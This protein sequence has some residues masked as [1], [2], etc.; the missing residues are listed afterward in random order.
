MCRLSVGTSLDDPTGSVAVYRTLTLFDRVIKRP[1]IV[2]PAVVVVVALA[3]GLSQLGASSSSGGGG[4]APSRSAAQRQLAGSPPALDALHRDADKLL[5]AKDYRA[6]I[7]A[8]KGF[9]IV[10]NIWGSWCVPCRQEFPVFQRV[11]AA[12]GREVAF[13]GVDT[14]DPED[15]ALKFLAANPLSY[16]SFQDLDGSLAKS[17]GII[18]TPSTIYY[19]KHGEQAYLHQGPY[20]EDA[21]LR[22]DIE[23]YARG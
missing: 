16:P 6:R 4:P 2:I 12:L 20:R 3:I 9:P 11:S 19:D 21:D 10:V 7:A 8:L 22:A 15:E 14:Q 1:Q 5:P 23:R 17:F 13:V 18:G